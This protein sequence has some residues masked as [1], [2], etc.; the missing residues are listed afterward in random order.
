MRQGFGAKY[1]FICTV[2]FMVMGA[3]AL[4]SCKESI[5]RTEAIGSADSLSTQTIY[6]VNA[7]QSDHGRIT[8]RLEAPLMENFSL[9]PEPFESFPQGIKI[10][11]YTPEGLVESEITARQ[12]IRKTGN[13]ERWEAFGDV[14]IINFIKEERVE[15]DTLYWDIAGRKIYTHDFIRYFAPDLFVQG[16]GM[17]SDERAENIK[18]LNPFYS[19]LI[20][21][22]TTDRAPVIPVDSLR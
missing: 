5:E 22:D 18:V 7:L 1:A 3:T 21:R 14:V 11:G 6:Q 4:F 17:E 19:Y 20:M 8:T 10:T 13:R 16:I 12:A 15:T 2:A 9:L